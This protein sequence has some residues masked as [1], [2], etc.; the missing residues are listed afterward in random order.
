MSG[1]KCLV[2]DRELQWKGNGFGHKRQYEGSSRMGM[3]CL[4]RKTYKMN[5]LTEAAGLF[6]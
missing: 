6:L 1:C 3:F 2:M 5:D 4:S